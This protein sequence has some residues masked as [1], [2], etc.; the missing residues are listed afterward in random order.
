MA[1]QQVD[2]TDGNSTGSVPQI[3]RE[4][5]QNALSTPRRHL[6]AFAGSV[7]SRIWRNAGGRQTHV[8]E[9]AAKR[10]GFEVS[11]IAAH[12]VSGGSIGLNGAGAGG[13]MKEGRSLAVARSKFL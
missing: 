13:C 2:G 7:G 10:Y 11:F 5:R 8:R 6:A 3:K 12:I 4:N 9:I 1:P